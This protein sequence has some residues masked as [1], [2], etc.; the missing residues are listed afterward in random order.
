MRFNHGLDVLSNIKKNIS[1]K[2]KPPVVKTV[3][4][5][6]LHP[7]TDIAALSRRV[8]VIC[9]LETLVVCLPHGCRMRSRLFCNRCRHRAGPEPPHCNCSTCLCS[10]H[11]WRNRKREETGEN[12][13]RATNNQPPFFLPCKMPWTC[14]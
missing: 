1:K 14:I 6:K 9:V 2:L 4:L 7:K 10:S 3:T 12:S 8:F 11:L 13:I 5:F